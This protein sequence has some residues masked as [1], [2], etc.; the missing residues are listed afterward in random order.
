MIEVR[1]NG[2][3]LK[4]AEPNIGH[5]EVH[6]YL[7][8]ARDEPSSLVELLETSMH[9]VQSVDGMDVL[10]RALWSEWDS[11]DEG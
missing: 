1:T 5:N 4:L 2:K 6:I 7:R 11:L 8:N 3:V 9:R 10:M